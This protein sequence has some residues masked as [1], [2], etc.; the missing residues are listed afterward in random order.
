MAASESWFSARPNDSYPD[1]DGDDELELFRPH[2]PTYASRP[3]SRFTFLKNFSTKRLLGV[4]ALVAA[5]PLLYILIRT[6]LRRFELRHIPPGLYSSAGVLHAGLDPFHIK[7]ISWYGMEG[8][9]H[10]FEGLH[11]NSLG[12]ILNVLRTHDFNAIRVPIALDNFIRDPVVH[13]S[14]ISTFANPE[15]NILNYRELLKAF[16]RRAAEKE[17]LVLLDLHRLEAKVWP[18]DGLWYSKKTDEEMVISVWERLAKDYRN[19]WNVI[20]ADL[21]NEVCGDERTS[22]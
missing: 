21:F 5:L 4:L 10:C 2:L 20:G 15:L 13:G 1:S 18:T 6:A 17:I 14:S 12:N 7:G 8:P 19:E 3:P 9:E 16:V 22:S 11:K